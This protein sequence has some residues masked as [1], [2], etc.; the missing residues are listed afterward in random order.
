MSDGAILANA[1]LSLE[2]VRREPA[3]YVAR[4]GDGNETTRLEWVRDS[5]FRFFP[6]VPDE[7]FGYRL[8]L[9]DI[10]MNKVLAAAGRRE[11][12]DVVDLLT[13]EERGLPLVAIVWAA[14]AKDPGFSPESLAQEILRFGI[15]QQVD[16]DELELE[17]PCNAG[18]VS[19][20]IKSSMH[21]AIAFAKS[22]P[23]GLAGHLFLKGSQIVLPDPGDL[24][25]VKLHTGQRK[26]HWPSSPEIGSAM[27]QEG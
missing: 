25:A 2:W 18:D 14:A 8:H 13:I 3:V 24:S 4:I 23:P 22:M 1:G 26:G 11:P 20:R 19:R 5:D 27:V 6:A 21:L 10:A 12:R 15:Y 9:A 17:I 16:Y 7:L